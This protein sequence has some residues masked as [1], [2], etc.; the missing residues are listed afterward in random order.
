M[1]SYVSSIGIE[2]VEIGTGGF[3]VM[4]TYPNWSWDRALN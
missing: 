4:L 1:L 3:L 2:S